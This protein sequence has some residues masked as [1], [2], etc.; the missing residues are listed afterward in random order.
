MFLT[1]RTSTWMMNVPCRWKHSEVG[2]QLEYQIREHNTYVCSGICIGTNELG[3]IIHAIKWLINI[4]SV[5]WIKVEVHK[6]ENVTKRETHNQNKQIKNHKF[7]TNHRIMKLIR[8]L[9]P[10][11]IELVEGLQTFS[12]LHEPIWRK[13]ENVQNYNSKK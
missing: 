9:F 1:W 3:D 6:V 11:L 10:L 7:C 2:N 4:K 8:C 13:S 5:K 12:W